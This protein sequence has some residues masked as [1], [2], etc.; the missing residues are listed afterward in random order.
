MDV[1]H[2][3]LTKIYEQSG[4]RDSTDVDLA[5]MLKKEGFF[6][7]LDN[8]SQ[9]LIGE[10]WVTET[11]KR[12]VVRIT[13]WGV[14]EAKKTLAGAPDKAQLIEKDSKRLISDTR[15][16]LVMLEEFSGSPEG[17]KFEVINKRFNEIGA[18][19]AKI[20]KNL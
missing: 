17:G 3:V 12:Y 20:A 7:S 9:F 1:Y 8:I 19:L 10:S 13:H 11:A 5:E 18:T 2:K 16:F 15:E 6:P 14:A 4:G